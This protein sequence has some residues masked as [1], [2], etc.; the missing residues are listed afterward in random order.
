MWEKPEV[1]QTHKPRWAQRGEWGEKV[2]FDGSKTSKQWE[3]VRSKGK[4]T[5]YVVGTR[6]GKKSL[7]AKRG[8]SVWKGGERAGS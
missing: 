6:S 7:P 3:L 8:P 1:E 5:Q 4:Q 2:T